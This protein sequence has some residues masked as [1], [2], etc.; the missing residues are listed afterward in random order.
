MRRIY[1]IF[2]FCGNRSVL[3]NKK[4]VVDVCR[5]G[6][7]PDLVLEDKM[8]MIDIYIRDKQSGLMH[9]VGDD[10][11]DMLTINAEGQLCY[12]NLQNGDGCRT[13]ETGGGYEFVSNE[14]DHGYN[15]VPVRNR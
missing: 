12:R 1:G 7:V 5:G 2:N 10:I 8:S 11:H 9:R 3:G 4:H 6:C 15:C 13:G 14:D